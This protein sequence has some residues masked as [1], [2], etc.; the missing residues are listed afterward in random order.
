MERGKKGAIAA[1]AIG[2]AVLI[3]GIVFLLAPGS[4][5]PPVT[6]GDDTNNTT[7][8]ASSGEAPKMLLLLLKGVEDSSEAVAQYEAN[9]TEPIQLA[10]NTH[11]RFESSDYRTAEG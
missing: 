9:N 7:T 8:V 5:F 1:S 2:G 6:D 10:T 4:I 11:I 3:A